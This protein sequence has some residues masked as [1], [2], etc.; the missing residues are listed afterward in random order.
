MRAAS[1]RLSSLVI[2]ERSAQAI[3]MIDAMGVQAVARDG[4]SS[5]E[6]GV[7]SAHDRNKSRNDAET[8]LYCADYGKFL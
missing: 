5:G 2:P 4:L 7:F 3:G 1:P 6:A 8:Q